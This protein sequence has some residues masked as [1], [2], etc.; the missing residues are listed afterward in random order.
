MQFCLI[1]F[2]SVT[3]AQRAQVLLRREGISCKLQRTPR[4]LE[5]QGCG[6]CLRVQASNAH[7]AIEHLGSAGIDY[8]K[9]YLQWEDGRLEELQL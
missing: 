5:S 7:I 9:V 6:Y 3:P 4:H 1:T 8:R 2:R